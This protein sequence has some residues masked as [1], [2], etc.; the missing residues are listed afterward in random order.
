MSNIAIVKCNKSPNTIIN[1]V[2]RR[3]AQGDPT[4]QE[5]A[6]CP[7]GLG[8]FLEP[9]DDRLSILIWFRLGLLGLSSFRDGLLDDL[10]NVRE[11]F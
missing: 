5:E 1:R 8:R 11:W 7:T 10:G 4:R 2:T 9:N 6:S 3:S